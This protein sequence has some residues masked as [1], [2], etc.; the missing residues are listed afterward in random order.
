MF[1][2]LFRIK[3]FR[4]Q[5]AANAVSQ[6]KAAVAEKQLALRD[7]K[8]AVSEYNEFRLAEEP[9]LFEEIR[10]AEVKLE[11]LE[12]MKQ[13]VAMMRDHE[14]KLQETVKE[15]ETAVDTA[16]EA[17]EAAEAA[18][19]EARKELQKFEEFVKAQREEA[20]KAESRKEEGEV[21]EISETAFAS[22]T[23]GSV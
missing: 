6:A 7:A 14:L 5:D 17:L 19:H 9:R 12:E 4:E 20:E 3:E 2:E 16:K 22:R 8:A 21:E 11:K 10:G 18:Y 13:K 15:A 23:R 1:E